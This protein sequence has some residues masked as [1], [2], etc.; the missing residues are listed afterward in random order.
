MRLAIAAAIVANGLPA[1]SES[2]STSSLSPPSFSKKLENDI[3][4][5]VRSIEG[6]Q[7]SGKFLNILRET[8]AKS[9][10]FQLKNAGKEE[11][12]VECDPQ[13]ED[14]DV[15]VLSCGV[16]RYCVESDE[17]KKGGLCVASH[18]EVDRGLQGGQGILLLGLYDTFCGPESGYLD[19]CN[20]TSIDSG[21]YALQ[22]DC[23]GPE[24]C[25]EYTS[26]C[27]QNATSCISY[28]FNFDL[29]APGTYVVNRCFDD[30]LPYSQKTCYQVVSYGSGQA[31]SCVI[32][33]DDED[34]LACS[35]SSTLTP[36]GEETCYTFDCTNTISRRA[37]DLCQ[38]GVYVSPLL[39]YLRTYGCDYYIC[40]ICGGE[41]FVSTNPG[42]SIVLGEGQTTCATV[43]QVALLGG[44]NETFCRDVVIPGV[45]G[46][47]GCVAF[48]SPPVEVPAEAPTVV[49]TASPVAGS[50]PETQFPSISPVSLTFPPSEAVIVSVASSNILKSGVL[51]AG[52]MSLSLAAFLQLV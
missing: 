38:P 37:G 5:T 35:V 2:S 12:L 13:S 4:H 16:G 15:G 23:V 21:V 42:G 17:S 30:S 29:S 47:C 34:C 36:E 41:D 10:G 51:A 14:A 19:T 26:Q 28:S 40:P 22:V 20:C 32:S 52:L 48:G 24:V 44:F 33:V 6:R 7:T 8:K 9:I 25:N 27:D 31:E 49:K 39:Y 50:S 11:E 45:A 46:P 43:E 1:T 18:N 3:F